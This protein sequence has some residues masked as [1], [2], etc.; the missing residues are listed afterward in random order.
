MRRYTGAEAR[1]LREAAT[2]GEWT[3]RPAVCADGRSVLDVSGYDPR[4]GSVT[5]ASLDDDADDDAEAEARV[6]DGNAAIIIASRDLAATVEALEAERDEARRSLDDVREAIGS[7][8]DESAWPPGMTVP[9]AV[10]KL[11]S[12]V[13]R[14]E[15]TC[16]LLY[17]D[18][19]AQHRVI[20]DAC[21]LLGVCDDSEDDW[22]KLPAYV[23][24]VRDDA[25]SAAARVAA[26]EADLAEARLCLLA[27]A[28]DPRGA[29]GLRGAWQHSATGWTLRKEGRA[30]AQ[31]R[32]V[33][34]PGNLPDAP[35]F[36]TWA[37][38]GDGPRGPIEEF[39]TYREAMRW[40]EREV[41]L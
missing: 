31:V 19:D 23:E 12:R 35:S 2:P 14:A 8:A 28:G 40:V 32:R 7:G 11:A 33:H 18:V 26:L 27:E 17:G 36:L 39:A 5:V 13:Y 24:R 25:K 21:A 1:A 9:Q 6:R 22:P 3:L 29:E 16:A 20:S 15:E 34:P 4:S 38:A 41:G 10:A 30:V 37:T